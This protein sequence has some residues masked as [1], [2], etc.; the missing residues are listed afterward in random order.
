MINFYFFNNNTNIF[1]VSSENRMFEKSVSLRLAYVVASST[2]MKLRSFLVDYRV[3]YR[4]KLT[5]K[6]GVLL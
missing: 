6:K 5:D 1:I 4:Q 3:K 2:S